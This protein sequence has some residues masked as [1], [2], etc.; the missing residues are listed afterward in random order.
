MGSRWMLLPVMVAVWLG[1]CA[2]AVSVK[3]M[4]LVG[5]IG[6]VALG[7]AMVEVF[8][9]SLWVGLMV[10]DTCGISVARVPLQPNRTNIISN[11]NPKYL[12]K[13]RL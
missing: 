5:L 9:V 4:E 1:G 10:S 13:N 12:N 7:D 3:S 2:V 11:I 8:S 6:C